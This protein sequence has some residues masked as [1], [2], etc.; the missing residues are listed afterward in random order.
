MIIILPS[1]LWTNNEIDRIPTRLFRLYPS[2]YTYSSTSLF[3]IPATIADTIL[4]FC[5]D[6]ILYFDIHVIHFLLSILLVLLIVI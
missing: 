5:P 6:S 1:V 4:H 2:G 3:V